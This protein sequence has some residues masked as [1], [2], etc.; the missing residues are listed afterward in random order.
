MHAAPD[1]AALLSALHR[2][3]KDGDMSQAH[4]LGAEGARHGLPE[5]VFVLAAGLLERRDPR[6][7]EILG[8][9][10]RFPNHAPGWLTIGTTLLGLGQGEA[11]LACFARAARHGTP[12]ERRRAALGQAAGLEALSRPAEAAAALE[13]AQAG[14]PDATLDYRRG[15]LL[16]RAGKPAEAQ[17][18][19]ERAIALEPGHAEAQFA[20]GLLH[21]DVGAQA[22]AA[23]AYRAALDRRPDF[24]EAALNLA[25]AEQ[26]CGRWEDALDAYARAVRLRPDCIGRVAQA[27]S[28]APRGRLWLDPAAL[29]DALAARA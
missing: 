28:A 17:A 12:A 6:A 7:G 9:L 1:P 2:A 10:E 23:T 27:L 3:L 24:H 11:A 13:E 5:P 29:I 21:Q 4:H 22:A 25:T 20:L 15:L 16:R 18:A 8:A 14:Q 19:L 26:A